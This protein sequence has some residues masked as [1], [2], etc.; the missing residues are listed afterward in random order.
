MR[1]AIKGA[2]VGAAAL[3]AVAGPT[4]VQAVEFDVGPGGVHVGERHHWDRDYD[5]GRCRT[6]VKERINDRG[7]RVTVCRRVC[8]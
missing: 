4:A 6:I 2:M 5:R 7:D 1:F 3:F 8:E